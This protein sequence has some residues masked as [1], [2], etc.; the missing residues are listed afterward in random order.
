MD[1]LGDDAEYE[2]EEID[3]IKVRVLK[4]KSQGPSQ[5]INKSIV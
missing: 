3:G 5:E 2:E 1:K 4:K